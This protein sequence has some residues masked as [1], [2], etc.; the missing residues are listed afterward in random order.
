MGLK[1]IFLKRRLKIVNEER[2]TLTN[3]QAY[4]EKEQ[5][6]L[7]WHKHKLKLNEQLNSRFNTAGEGISEL[8]GRLKM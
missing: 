7:Q 4:L 8:K 3:D 5:I 6:E 2:E 1:D